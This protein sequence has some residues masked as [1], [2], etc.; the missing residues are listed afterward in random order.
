MPAHGAEENT[1]QTREEQVQ[2][3]EAEYKQEPDEQG[4]LSREGK[5]EQQEQE[6][7]KHEEDQTNDG[8]VPRS[9]LEGPAEHEQGVQEPQQDEHNGA[10]EEAQDADALYESGEY[11]DYVDENALNVGTDVLDA[12]EVHRFA[13][14]E[15]GGD[16][17]DEKDVAPEDDER[18]FGEDLPEEFGG[19][20]EG[21]VEQR[22]T[23]DDV[24]EGDADGANPVSS[25]GIDVLETPAFLGDDFTTV[26]EDQYDAGM[27]AFTVAAVALYSY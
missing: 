19:E 9:A 1:N 6:Q 17:V 3:T 24:V 12:D 16:Y 2:E 27:S 8:S 18:Q 15:E 4:A 13:D 11:Q 22:Q 21:D 25:G 26:P 5:Q 10:Q 23:F 7:E 20:P 14:A